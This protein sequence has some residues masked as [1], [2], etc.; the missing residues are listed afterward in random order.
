MAFGFVYLIVSDNSLSNAQTAPPLP[1]SSDDQNVTSGSI[2]ILNG[3]AS[4]SLDGSPIKEYRWYEVDSNK[5]VTLKGNGTANPSFQVNVSVPTVYNFSLRVVDSKGIVSV[6]PDEVSIFVKPRANGTTSFETN[7]E[8][9]Q[10]MPSNQTNTRSLTFSN[11]TNKTSQILP[12]VNVSVIFRPTNQS[13][14]SV[15]STAANTTKS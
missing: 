4:H 9:P 6:I 15:P 10:I 12:Q 13:F 14:P 8:T 1:N 5:H 2:V 3:S 11:Q 7:T